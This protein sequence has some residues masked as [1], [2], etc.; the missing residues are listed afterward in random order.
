MASVD[1]KW[2]HKRLTLTRLNK[3]VPQMPD[4]IT[5]FVVDGDQ[6]VRRAMSRLMRAVG[7]RAVCLNS[8]DA[9]LQENLPTSGA[10][11]L[12]D[13]DTARQFSVALQEPFKSGGLTLPVIFLTDC[14]SERTRR[15][16]RQ[17]G[18][19]GYFRKPVDEQALSDAITFA[20]RRKTNHDMN[21]RATTSHSS[22][23]MK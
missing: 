10:I 16:A 7:F 21:E 5:V 8:L 23:G 20:V 4:L 9:L 18:A 13:V 12:L 2:S 17:M 3:S 6:S 1:N 14:D 22:N 11:I 19:S 15:E